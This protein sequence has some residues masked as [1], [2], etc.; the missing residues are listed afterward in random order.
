MNKL[1]LFSIILI[2]CLSV[3]CSDDKDEDQTQKDKL[4]NTRWEHTDEVGNIYK[5]EF[6]KN[7]QLI[8]SYGSSGAN[9]GIYEGFYPIYAI[10]IKQGLSI[11]KLDA[12][13]ESNKITL[14]ENNSIYVILAKK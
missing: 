8:W 11:L 14:Y 5:L 9:I 12:V 2:F 10:K 4:E 1:K 7:N 3:S 6:L 13:V